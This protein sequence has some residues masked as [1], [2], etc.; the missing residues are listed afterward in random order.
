MKHKNVSTVYAATLLLF[1]PSLPV[2][3]M[4]KSDEIFQNISAN[5]FPLS[6]NPH[7]LTIVIQNN[8]IVFKQIS[9]HN[10]KWYLLFL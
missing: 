8:T 7:P 6:L 9:V 3:K 5:L 10:E 4:S 1:V 2:H